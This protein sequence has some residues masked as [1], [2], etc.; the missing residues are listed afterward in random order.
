MHPD[1]KRNL[2]CMTYVNYVV[3]DEEDRVIRS[4][5][6]SIVKPAQRKTRVTVQVYNAAFGLI[7]AEQYQSSLRNR[8]LS[9]EDNFANA[10][11]AMETIFE[12]DTLNGVSYYIIT[13]PERYLQN[14]DFVRRVLNIIYQVNS[15]VNIVKCL[16]FVGASLVVP[17]KLSSY[18]HVIR[19]DYLGREEIQEILDQMLPSV[20]ERLPADAHTWFTGLTG[21]QVRSAAGQ[22]IGSTK[23]DPDPERR[24]MITRENVLQ[25][26]REKI[27]KTDL[28]KLVDTSAVTFDSVGG[29]D[30][31]KKWAL[32]TKHAWTT[33]GKAYGLKPPKG[34]LAVGVWGC[35]KSLSMKALG[36]AWGLPVIQLELGKLRDSGVG[37]TE[38]NTYR[39]IR[40]LEAMAPCVTGNTLVMLADGTARPIEEL[41]LESPAEL[42]VMCWNERTL[43][44]AETRVSGITRRVADAFRVSTAN[45]F[46]LCATANH[47]HYVMRGGMSEWVRTDELQPGDM[48]AV[49]LLGEHAAKL[50]ELLDA[51]CRW[52][53]LREVEPVGESVVYDL[54]CEGQ[55]THSFIANGLITHNCVAWADEAEKSFSGS[56]S[57]SYSDAGTTAR[58][59]GILSTWHQETTAEVC[60]ALTTNSLKTLPVEFTNRINERFFFDLPSE[61]DRVD[62]LKIHLKQ[63]GNLSK[64]QISKFDLRRLAEASENLVPREM[65][66]A[67]Y[68]ALLKSFVAKKPSLDFEIFEKELKTKPRILKT[69]DT[70]LREVLNWVGYD[71]DTH[72]GLRARYASTK[73]SA[74]TMRILEG[75]IE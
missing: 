42:R 35:G 43:R 54:I 69:M 75:G 67:V 1:L 10:I 30:R 66:Q 61:D 21:F 72:D 26:K 34:V 53:A 70:E 55:D 24:A 13:D 9:R 32:D 68:A 40:Y 25:Y 41:W 12:E 58:A 52:V 22:S 64:D 44:V 63:F 18:L 33:E 6:N 7:P 8:T 73:Q 16:Y 11:K 49:P 15:N 47:Q 19:D 17:Q 4:I 37:N 31:F 2:K 71:E 38:A 5:A 46:S 29:I 36:N 65:E 39:V 45:G 3:T 14:D 20:R 57:S 28:L 51:E 50:R 60:L 48:L 59:L 27:R 62:I 74:S 56:H 23:N